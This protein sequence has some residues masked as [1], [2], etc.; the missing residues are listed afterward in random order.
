MKVII[1]D[2]WGIRGLGVYDYS[3]CDALYRKDINLILITNCYYEY[4]KLSN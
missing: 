2:P 3:L 1:Q 4:D